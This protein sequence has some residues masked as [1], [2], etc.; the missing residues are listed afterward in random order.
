MKLCN[1]DD[2][3][4]TFRSLNIKLVKEQTDYT[5]IINKLTI[6]YDYIKEAINII[7]NLNTDLFKLY[8]GL[9][10]YDFCIDEGINTEKLKIK[11]KYKKNLSL[12]CNLSN[13]NLTLLKK[14]F[15]QSLNDLHIDI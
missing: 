15:E 7:N 12:K 14:R 8:K 10:K 13:H 1:D 3:I 5:K 4:A 2:D 11:D 9:Y 6:K